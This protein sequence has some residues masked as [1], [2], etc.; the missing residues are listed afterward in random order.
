M[1]TII[2]LAIGFFVAAGVVHA[3]DKPEKKKVCVEV[4]DK[5]GKKKEECKMVTVHKKLEGTPVPPK[6]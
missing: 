5:N 1:K 6:K 3:A 2:T 4:A